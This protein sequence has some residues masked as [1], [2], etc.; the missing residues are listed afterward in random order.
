MNLKFLSSLWFGNFLIFL[1][2]LVIFY[3]YQMFLCGF[4]FG[5]QC[6]IHS[7]LFLFC[8]MEGKYFIGFEEVVYSSILFKLGF[9]LFQFQYNDVKYKGMVELKIILRRYRNQDYFYRGFWVFFNLRLLN[10]VC[11]LVYFQ[12]FRLQFLKL[13]IMKKQFL[14]NNFCIFD[15]SQINIWFYCV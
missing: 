6:C 15:F 11:F 5:Y 14:K 9:N 13:F 7:K 2:S 10:F 8:W 4:F 1:S 3:C 12:Q